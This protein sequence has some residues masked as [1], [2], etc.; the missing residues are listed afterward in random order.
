[1][2]PYRSYQTV[3]ESVEK[4]DELIVRLRKRG[5]LMLPP[6]RELGEIIGCSRNTARKLLE[7][8]EAEGVIIKNQNGRTLSMK[9][10]GNKKVLG[11]FSF[12]AEGRSMVG[13]P[14][15]A[16]LWHRLQQKAEAAGICAEL[17]LYPS[18]MKDFDWKAFEKS[19]SDMIVL[20]TANRDILDSVKSMEGKTVITTEEHFRGQ[21]GNI[22]G[23]DNYKVGVLAAK[24]LAKHG[25]KRPAMIADMLF[26]DGRPYVQYTKRIEGFKD[27]CK[28]SHLQFDDGSLLIVQGKSV[29]L[30]VAIA[31][32]AMELARR[33]FDSVFLYTDVDIEFLMEGLDSEG[34]KVP[35]QMG[36]I[37]VNSFDKAVSFNP[38]VD[39]VTHGTEP[40]ADMLIE[41]MKD[42]FNGGEKDFGECLVE[43]G[44]HE[45][46]T[47]K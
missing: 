33:D 6:E 11:T 29:K 26:H 9:T 39:S 30:M 15:W 14:A 37:T 24:T 19:L 40:M 20:T 4:F 36:V 35:E 31:K 44:I 22:V 43:P 18:D 32:Q 38:P 1:M 5:E 10:V 7:L 28:K 27:G 47:L 12:V 17:V 3:E 2:G 25:Y 45:G 42:I 16:K 46:R 13:N 21:I 34:V 23:L 41:K 8:K